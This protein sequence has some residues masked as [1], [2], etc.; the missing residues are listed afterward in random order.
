[1]LGN[2]VAIFPTTAPYLTICKHV[3]SHV[4]KYTKMCDYCQNLFG[5]L[6]EI[7]SKP[8][9]A[10]AKVLCMQ[11]LGYEPKLKIVCCMQ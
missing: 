5:T 4:L 10:P 3:P 11:K 6:H 9:H 7:C 2:A 1:M 8:L